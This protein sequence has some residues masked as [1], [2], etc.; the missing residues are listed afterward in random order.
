MNRDLERELQA[1]FPRFFQDLYGD[2]RKTGMA[3][4]LLTSTFTVATPSM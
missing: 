2:P 3:S 4:G 1:R